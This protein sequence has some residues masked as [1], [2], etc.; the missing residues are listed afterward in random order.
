MLFVSIGPTFYFLEDENISG[1]ATLLITFCVVLLVATLWVSI[2]SPK[3]IL[4][5]ASPTSRFAAFLVD[6]ILCAIIPV[7][8]HL[9]LSP[10]SALLFFFSYS[11]FTGEG[12]FPLYMYPLL[13]IANFFAYILVPILFPAI[14]LIY[15]A[16][17]N[18]K[19]QTLGQK[20]LG[21]K[22][23]KE[24]GSLLKYKEAFLR[25]IYFNILYI[26]PIVGYINFYFLFNSKRQNVYDLKY[27]VVVKPVDEKKF[28]GYLVTVIAAIP[29]SF[30]TWII[31]AILASTIFLYPY[32]VITWIFSGF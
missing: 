27:K 18:S 22:I 16:Y 20:L 11:Y 21:I 32:D 7:I 13:F 5:I 12:Q 4:N 24:D 29:I 8:I 2:K 19:G 30:V 31:S 1:F 14:S 25:H 10:V 17:F 15:F 9:I 26:L 6:S 23:E 28:I 3:T